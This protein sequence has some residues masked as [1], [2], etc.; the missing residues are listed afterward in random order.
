MGLRAIASWGDDMMFARVKW[1]II[2]VL[3]L[4]FASAANSQ[5]CNS[6]LGSASCNVPGASNQAPP[7]ASQS[8]WNFGNAPG[9]PGLGSDLLT[10][11]SDNDTA[12]LGGIV[13]GGSG[14]TCMGPF[15]WRKC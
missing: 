6:L 1:T 15:R 14:A 3:A 4:T 13:F 12:M 5:T 10:G 2:G 9:S 11:Q 7:P 8:D